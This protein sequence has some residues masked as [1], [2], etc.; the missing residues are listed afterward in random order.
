[1]QHTNICLFKSEYIQM[2]KYYTDLSYV[3]LSQSQTYVVYV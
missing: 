1:M 3:A 2:P